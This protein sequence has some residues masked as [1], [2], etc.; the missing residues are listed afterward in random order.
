M[1][2]FI[3]VDN[4]NDGG[5]GRVASVLAN[6]ICTCNEVHVI[7]KESEVKYSVDS[8]VKIHTLNDMTHFWPIRVIKRI[9]HYSP[10]ASIIFSITIN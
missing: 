7:V 4:L 6:A 2:V 9:L 5:A 1:K 8:S 3:H 10:I